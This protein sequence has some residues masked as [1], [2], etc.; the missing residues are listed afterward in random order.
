MYT[1]ATTITG[2]GTVTSGGGIACSGSP[3]TGTCSAWY[4]AGTGVTL[5]AAVSNSVFSG[6]GGACAP[7]GGNVS[8]P[9]TIDAPKSCGAAFVDPSSL[10]FISGTSQT[11]SSLNLAY[12]AAGNSAIIKAQAATFDE[13]LL[14]DVAGRKVTI[15]GGYG[16]TF[17]TQSGYTTVQGTLTIG[18]G[19]LVAD[20]VTIR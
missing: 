4:V 15:K 9:V 5:T 16:P 7:C 14:I 12:A 6:W 18:K 13:N 20:R 3:Q 19:G 10:V 17:V 1:L 11:F 8:C 2:N